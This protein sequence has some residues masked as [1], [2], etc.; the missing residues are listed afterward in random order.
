M[1]IR[2]RLAALWARAARR[3]KDVTLTE[4][5]LRPSPRITMRVYRAAT[6]EWET[7]KE[8]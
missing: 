1:S 7:V 8:E 6:K 5:R 3:E 4:V 2:S